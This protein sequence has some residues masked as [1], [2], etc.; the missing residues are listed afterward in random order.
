[1]TSSKIHVVF[2]AGVLG[3]EIARQ[4]ARS[5]E[6]VRLATRSGTS[7][8]DGAEP[9]L[10]DL[11]DAASVKAAAQDAD[12]IYFCGAPPYQNWDREF[13]ALQEGA[14][15][16]AREAGAILVAAENLYGYGVAGHL[17]EALP[18][19]AKTRKGA[20]RARMSH[21]LFEAHSGGEIRAVSGRASDFF[22]PDVRISAL[23]DRF[24]PELLKGKPVSWFGNPD[25]R[26]TFTYLPDFAGAL[27]DLGALPESWGRAWHVPSP[28]T[29]TLRQF[30]E[31][32][33]RLAGRTAP[34]IRQTP[35]LVLRL[36]GLAIP[37]AGEMVEMEYAFANDFVM[38]QDDWNARFERRAT[39]LDDALITTIESW[40]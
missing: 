22:G 35:R 34:K 12:V 19:V 38:A 17:H 29:M 39:E 24:W 25:K 27:I 5:G 9:V 13:Y 26:H 14:I 15:I 2:G 21:R 3:K 1:M 37:A 18:L 32:V 7:L 11:R 33:S 30:A 6:L 8:V 4:L 10:A 28:E 36:L 16:A 31:Q 40:K 23:G 20:V